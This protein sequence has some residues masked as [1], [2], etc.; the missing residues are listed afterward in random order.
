MGVTLRD[1]STNPR[2]DDG[3]HDF[4]FLFGSWRVHNRKLER[5]FAGIPEWIE[6]GT[7]ATAR[8]ILE[9]LGNVDTFRAE[10]SG[11]REA[12][13]GCTLRLFDP[14]ERRWSIHWAST[15]RPGHLDPPVVGRFDGELGTFYG[16][17]RLG[18]RHIR[19]RFEW[20]ALGAD[21]ARW[22]QAFSADDGVTW[23]RNWIMTFMRDDTAQPASSFR[24]S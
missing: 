14:V 5:P 16:E 18:D 10:A 7:T 23:E 22:E 3:R 13:E 12:W 9:G 19:V 17:D 8:P 24:E 15:K 6:F 11:G 21:G 4:D 1:M 2:E 20:Q